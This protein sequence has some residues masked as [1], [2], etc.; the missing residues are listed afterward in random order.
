MK[1]R[2][3]YLVDIATG[4]AENKETLLSGK[5]CSASLFL[6]DLPPAANLPAAANSANLPSATERHNDF[7][8]ADNQLWDPLKSVVEGILVLLT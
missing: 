7:P 2:G 4:K 3:K 5:P 1:S 8:A 6:K